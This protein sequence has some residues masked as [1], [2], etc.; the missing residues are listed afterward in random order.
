MQS[1]SCCGIELK[2][3][4]LFFAFIKVPPFFTLCSIQTQKKMSQY[5][6]WNKN[7]KE[8]KKLTEQLDLFVS[9]KG[10]AGIDPEI[11]KPSVILSEIYANYEYLKIF[12]PRYFP[13]RYRKLKTH[14]LTAKSSDRARETKG[15]QK[16]YVHFTTAFFF[17]LIQSCSITTVQTVLTKKILL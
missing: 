9:T 6:Q 8:A 11:Q 17:Y 1:K 13:D 4:F 15:K 14:W 5:K 7:S 10:A 3:Q 16:K 2:L 12:N